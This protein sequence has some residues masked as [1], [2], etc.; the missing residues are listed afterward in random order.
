LISINNEGIRV[1]VPVHGKKHIGKGLLK[2][3]L[4]DARLSV[5]ELKALI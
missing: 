4:S 3:I 2:Q 5:D 1:T